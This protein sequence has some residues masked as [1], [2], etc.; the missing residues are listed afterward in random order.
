MT[1]QTI[2]KARYAELISIEKASRKL[3]QAFPAIIPSGHETLAF[4]IPTYIVEELRTA[5]P[6]IPTRKD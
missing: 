4:N 2:G 3:L 1:T 6:P 5:L